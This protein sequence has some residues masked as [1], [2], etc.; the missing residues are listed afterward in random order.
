MAV[1]NIYERIRDDIL[2]HTL[3]PAQE[4]DEKMLCERYEVS[5]TPIR[6]ALIRLASDGLVDFRPNRGARVA[7]IILSDFPRYLEALH[8]VKRA[9]TRLA[10]YRHHPV[11]IERIQSAYRE[12]E[13]IRPA[14]EESLE[15]TSFRF[16]NV[17][18]SL[19]LSIAKT[20]HNN[21]LEEHTHHLLTRGHRM[22]RLT[23][24]YQAHGGQS[25]A[26]YVASMKS[27]Y[28]A[29]LASI[30]QRLPEEA[31]DWINQLHQRLCIRLR[32]YLEENQT[33]GLGINNMN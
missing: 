26:S 28:G 22:L 8:L 5:R 12:F 14:S 21:Y 30:Q 29:L 32:E 15:A 23:Y 13:N 33:A 25:V 17:E 24:A 16:G 27:D 11:D 7:S 3:R 2:A 4:I 6:E 10:S 1:G 20:S 19:L 31:E 18:R 9:V